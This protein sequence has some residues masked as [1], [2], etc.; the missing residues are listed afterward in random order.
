MS[1]T[2][3][4]ALAIL[5]L[6]L[7]AAAS[8]PPATLATFPG[9][10]GSLVFMRPDAD[11]IFQAWVADADMTHQHQITFGPDWDAWFPS[12]SPDGRRIV[13][14]SHRADPDRGDDI[15]IS[16]VYTM[17]PDGSDIRKITDSVGYSGGASWSPDGRWLV[18]SAD[19]G[20]YP[21][22]V[23]IYATASDGSGSPRRI[24]TMPSTSTGQE[25]PRFSPDGKRLVF[26]EGR[27][28]ATTDPDQPTIEQLALFTVRFDGSNLRRITAWEVNGQDADWS[29]DGRRLVFAGRP[30]ENGNIQDV[31]LADE[32]GGHL[33]LLTQGDGISGDGDSFRYQ[34]SFNPAWAPDGSRIVFARAAYTPADGFVIGL[35]TIRPNSTSQTWLAQDEAHQP[36][37]G[38][39]LLRH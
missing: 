30:A 7:I 27:E 28:I 35:K 8:L 14:S 3:L 39:I 33:R 20:R 17:R 26:D 6:A 34:E 36:D 11:G 18:Y 38:R 29:P 21:A 9:A 1:S 10:N 5:A 16:D 13:F 24:T 37:W 19:R 12:W 22:G 4:R 32:D 2:R 15:E 25:L 31:M 23:G